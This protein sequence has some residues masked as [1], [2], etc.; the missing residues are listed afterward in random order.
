MKKFIFII[1]LASL[2]L[3]SAC[4]NSRDL[5]TPSSRLVGH[6]RTI[7]V[8]AMSDLYFGEIDEETGTGTFAEYDLRDGTLAKGTY[9]IVRE[10][11]GGE[12]ITIRTALFGYQDLD[13][14]PDLLN[15]E[16]DLEVQVDGLKAKMRKF[17]IEYVDEK[18]EFDPSDPAPTI[19]PTQTPTMDPN[20]TVYHPVMDEVALYETKT[21]ETVIYLLN[22]DEQL[23][24]TDGAADVYCESLM[25]HVYSPRLEVSGWVMITNLKPV[26]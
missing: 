24:A 9:T 22:K 13:I 21:R 14:P 19:A 2:L 8:V 20:I 23:I 5:S 16:S 25:C 6:W 17:Y 15:P 11:P 10:T 26:D 12:A 7:N 4:G 1:V 18:T 3:L